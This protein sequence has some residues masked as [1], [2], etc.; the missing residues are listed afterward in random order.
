MSVPMAEPLFVSVSRQRNK[1]FFCPVIFPFLLQNRIIFSSFFITMF[2]SLGKNEKTDEMIGQNIKGHF[3]RS[4]E[5][6]D[7]ECRST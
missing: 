6:L 1:F 5:N 4:L 7:C 3:S 2:A